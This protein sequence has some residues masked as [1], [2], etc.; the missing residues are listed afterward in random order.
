MADDFELILDECITRINHGDSL[1]D[2]LADHP[3]YADRLRPLLESMR[4]AQQAYDFIPSAEARRAAREKFNAALD[5]QRRRTPLAAFFGLVSRPLV[6]APVMVLIMAVAGIWWV[7]SAQSPPTLVSSPAGN[8]AFLISDAPNDIGDFRSL[9]ITISRVGLQAAGSDEWQEF[10]P[11]VN[12]VDLTELQG[13]ASR[14]IWR[15]EVPAGQ[16]T[17][18]F[19]YVSRVEGILK[20]TGQDISVKLPSGKLHLSKTFEVTADTISSF[21]F[22]VTV[23]ATGNSG[24]YILKPQIDES[25]VEQEPRPPGPPAAAGKAKSKK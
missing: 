22:D 8:F 24:K 7:R 18:V 10:V 25:G 11:D 9:N 19:I 4:R 23:I 17:Q 13:E 1:A 12:N 20:T 2:C 3:A 5:K 21:T 6:W 14:E 15:G 16:Y